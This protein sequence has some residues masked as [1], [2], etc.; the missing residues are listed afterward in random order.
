MSCFAA[1]CGGRPAADPP[2]DLKP[3]AGKYVHT[4]AVENGD[5]ANGATSKALPS[6]L[7]KPAAATS[8]VSREKKQHSRL[9]D[10]PFLQVFYGLQLRASR[11][12]LCH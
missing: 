5:K 11:M 3:P 8:Q 2:N 10:P 7:A 1:L 9:L 12:Q 4:S 6:E